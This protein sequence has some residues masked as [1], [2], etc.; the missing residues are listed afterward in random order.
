MILILNFITFLN[1]AS[2]NDLIQL[3]LDEEES[4]IGNVENNQGFIEIKNKKF[5]KKLLRDVIFCY[6]SL[7][8]LKINNEE[9]KGN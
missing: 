2:R 7:F 9:I 4:N 8:Y 3:L 5:T 1:K 6:C